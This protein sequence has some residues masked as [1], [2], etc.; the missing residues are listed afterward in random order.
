M[1]D[2][3]VSGLSVAGDRS[4]VPGS[5]SKIIISVCFACIWLCS[6]FVSSGLEGM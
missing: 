6:A 2:S 5:S 3:L 4:G 1:Q